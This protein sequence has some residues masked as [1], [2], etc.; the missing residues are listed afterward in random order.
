MV[1]LEKNVVTLGNAYLQLSATWHAASSWVEA[2]GLAEVT[3]YQLKI[4]LSS[5][6]KSLGDREY[7]LTGA[8]D[9]FFPMKPAVHMFHLERC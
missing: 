9:M 1:N 4:A 5:A 7:C 8:V 3:L 2:D 6:D